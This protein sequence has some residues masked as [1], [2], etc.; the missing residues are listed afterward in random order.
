[1][2]TCSSV[3]ALAF[4]VSMPSVAHAHLGHVGEL[5]G[6]GHLIGLGALIGASAL[7]AALAI[8][9]RKNRE[10]QVEDEAEN[11]DAVDEEQPEGATV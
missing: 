2:K 5:A 6:H 4:F 1:M 9:R 3:I 8:A 10:L 11:G 7:A